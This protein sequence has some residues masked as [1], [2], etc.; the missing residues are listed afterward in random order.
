MKKTE[1]ILHLTR[2]LKDNNPPIYDSVV[3]VEEK[4]N[5]ITHW[6]FRGLLCIAYDLEEKNDKL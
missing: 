2:Y 5:E 1:A 4:E 6:T 3:Y